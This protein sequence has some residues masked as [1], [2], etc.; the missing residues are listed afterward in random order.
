MKRFLLAALAALLM[1]APAALAR[2]HVTYV[3][4]PIYIAP[5]QVPAA[6][7]GGYD[8]VHK[9]AILSAIGT[10]MTLTVQHFLAP[11]TG[12]LDVSAWNLDEHAAATI[13]KYL[14]GRFSFADVPFDAAKLA[15][16][17][18]AWWH[19]GEMTKFLKTV[20]N[21]DLD[22]FLVVRPQ[23]DGVELQTGGYGNQTVL[24]VK[25]QMDLIDAHTYK[26]IASSTSRLQFRQGTLPD[27]PGRV[28]G[29]EFKLDDTLKIAPDKQE[30]LRT[31][32]DQMLEYTL[33]ET[34]RSLQFGV[35]L[36]PIGSHD[37]VPLQ[38][39]EKTVAAK[40][41]AVVS[42]IGAK[43]DLY[44]AGSTFTREI[45]TEV[46]VPE[47]NLDAEV[48]TMVRDA[49][50]PDYRIKSVAVDREALD[51]QGWSIAKDKDGILVPGLPESGEVDAFLVILK[52]NGKTAWHNAA[53]L[54]HFAPLIGGNHAYVVADYLMLL[55]DAKTHKSIAGRIGTM[56]AKSA[57]SRPL[58]K[59]EDSYWPKSKSKSTDKDMALSPQAATAIR[60]VLHDLLRD[61][62]PETLY[63]MGMAV[64]EQPADAD[65]PP[66]LQLK[67]VP[68][69]AA[70]AP[71]AATAGNQAP[72]A[73]PH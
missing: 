46:P 15:K 27:F 2:G 48:E 14:G 8:K 43:I 34:I 58:V 7:V 51:K 25:Y 26:T 18:P 57:H 19:A 22:A 61:S 71:D 66:E 63:R 29:D 6:D 39:S 44:Q 54:W 60:A 53:G 16:I 5:P 23:E 33:V 64:R 52:L 20:P 35:T 70:P 24:W 13:K 38:R 59:V 73:A 36:P 62:I 47:W 21:Q 72:P 1:L 68:A 55:V 10:G 30:K 28:V 67:P 4:V 42:D 41:I 45:E 50:A 49:L 3:Y 11:S 69:Q 65:L 17:L 32:T 12:K 31:L 40:S 37:I 9:V 56:N